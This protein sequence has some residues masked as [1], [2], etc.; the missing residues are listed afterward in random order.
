MKV[1]GIQTSPNEDG[2]TATTAQMALDGAQAA[3]ATSELIHLC[4][5]KLE[6]CR[7]CENGWGRCRREGKCIIEDD[8][9][10]IRGQIGAANAVVISTPVYFGDLS[11]VAKVFFDRLRR[12]ERHSDPSSLKGTAV[13]SI[14]AAGGGG[15]GGPTTLVNL[16]RYYGVLGWPVFDG[17]I[18]TR[19]SREYML[20]AARA[21]GEKLVR[22]VEEQKA[23]S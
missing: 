2:L 3:G 4:K 10:K 13:L 1:L 7:Q 21:A 8:F 6:A 5:A 19:R 15:G 23:A 9:E 22:H 12:C 14:A 16:E 18:V 11:E 20:V 17:M